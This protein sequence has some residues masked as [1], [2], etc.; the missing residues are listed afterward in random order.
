MSKKQARKNDILCILKNAPGMSIRSLAERMDVSEMTVRRDLRELSNEDYVSI[1]HGVAILNKNEDGST[2]VK[3]YSLAAERRVMQDAKQRIGA[4]AATLLEVNDSILV[5]TGTTTEQIFAHLAPGLPLTITCYNMNSL[6][7]CKDR[8][9]TALIF[10]GGFYHRNT[11]MFESPEGAQLISRICINKY[12]A[13]AAGIGQ[14][15]AVSCI[16]QHEL[17]SKQ[18]ALKAA[19]TRILMVD[20]TKFG[21]IRPCMFATLDDFDMVITDRDIAPEWIQLFADK[22]IKWML[23]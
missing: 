6:Q 13:S 18:S 12:F 2:I 9:N 15:G 5:D 4:M 21:K 19:A 22:G 16:E 17:P 10:A 14:R 1:I 11:Q 23:A 3:D 8:E 7:A 20:S